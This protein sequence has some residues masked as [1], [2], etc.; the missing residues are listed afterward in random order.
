MNARP[1]ELHA[2]RISIC[3]TPPI[4]DSQ[5]EKNDATQCKWY[6]RLYNAC[7]RWR[8]WFG[9]RVRVRRRAVDDTL[10]RREHWRLA[11]RPAGVGLADRFPIGR[12]GQRDLR[13][14]G[15]WWPGKHVLVST[16]WIASVRWTQSSV[17]VNLLRET[18]KAGSE[19]DPS[20]HVGRMSH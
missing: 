15:N 9:G 4:K 19:Y 6:A 20:T 2:Q 10:S 17:V 3:R 5:K 16:H 13:C 8:D 12:L 14:R 18:I 11:E 1:R 7:H